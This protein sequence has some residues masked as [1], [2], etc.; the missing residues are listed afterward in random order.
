MTKRKIK[1]RQKIRPSRK[2]QPRQTN[3][4]VVGGVIV[5]GA[6]VLFALLYVALQGRD[7]VALAD[8]CQNNPDACVTRGD[9][10]APVTVV[11]VSD[12]GCSHCRDFH[13]FTYDALM[14]AEVDSG[15]VYWVTMP[16]A[17]FDETLG[18]AS[19]S[20]CAAEQDAYSAYSQAMFAN[21]GN[22]DNLTQAGFERA[23]AE[24]GLDVAAFNAC[25]DDGRYVN[26]VQANRAAARQAGI[27]GTP[28]F[29]INGV[30]FGGALPLDT[31][32]ARI[33]NAIQQ[34]G[35]S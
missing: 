12:F 34:A 31:F 9:P 25:V 8:Y 4:L 15:R 13:V 21:F 30:S 1:R 6:V 23:A 24:G 26:T 19:A 7:P 35:G 11:E 10:D 2:A 22:S 20:M 17:L 5:V 14:E 32:Q 3:W 33:E 16:Y 28:T 27:S 18:A 29:I